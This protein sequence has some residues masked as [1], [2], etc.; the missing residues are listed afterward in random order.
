[1]DYKEKYLKYKTK[2]LTLKA[3]IG[4]GDDDD[5][6]KKETIDD[7][8]K[9]C[10]SITNIFKCNDKYQCNWKSTGINEGNCIINNETKQ[11][12]AADTM[13]TALLN[14][15]DIK[16]Q[17]CTNK[18]EKGQLKLPKGISRT[19][20][21]EDKFENEFFKCLINKDKSY[22]GCAI[23]PNKENE[24]ILNCKKTTCEKTPDGK[25]IGSMGCAMLES[26]CTWLP[27][28]KNKDGTTKTNKDGKKIKGLC[29]RNLQ[30]D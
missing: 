28:P 16:E 7:I 9:K 15:T 20:E 25:K 13:F 17:D 4:N 8:T 29:K 24:S 22:T 6:A 30:K 12:I 1:M 18:F 2:Y 23:V 27:P 3:Q 14:I 21:V 5:F 19:K 26:S 11:E 10:N